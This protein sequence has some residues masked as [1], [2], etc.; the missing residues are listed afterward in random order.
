MSKEI[1]YAPVSLNKIAH[2]I[3]NN[4]ISKENRKDSERTFVAVYTSPMKTVSRPLPKSRLLL[5]VSLPVLAGHHSPT[6]GRGT[7]STWHRRGAYVVPLGF[8]DLHPA[9]KKKDKNKYY[10]HSIRPGQV[11]EITMECMM[12]KY[13]GAEALRKA[14][15][16]MLP[17]NRCGR[18]DWRG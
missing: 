14:I 16:G 9:G 1:N 17:K 2:H 6:A 15:G 7:S 4:R 5:C 12:A 3:A 13:G 8:H 11:E 10:R 18:L